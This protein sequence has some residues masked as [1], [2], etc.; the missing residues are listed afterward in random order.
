MQRI[1]HILRQLRGFDVRANALVMRWMTRS[2][3]RAIGSL[4]FHT[5]SNSEVIRTEHVTPEA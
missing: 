1:D 5:G 3:I 2:W 4:C